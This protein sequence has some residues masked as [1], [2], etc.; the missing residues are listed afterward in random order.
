MK[1]NYNLTLI[2]AGQ[3]GEGAGRDGVGLKSVS[4]SLHCPEVKV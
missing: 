2:N 1:K 4:P 3:G